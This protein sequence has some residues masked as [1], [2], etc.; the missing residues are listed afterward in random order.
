M[1]ACNGRCEGQ[2]VPP[3]GKAECEASARAQTKLDVECTPPRIVLDYALRTDTDADARSRFA[4]AM[5]NLRESL[6][7]LSAR[8]EQAKSVSA[9][10]SDLVSDARVAVK[11]GIQSA[12]KAVA[13]GDLRTIFGLACAAREVD[14]V[15]DAIKD[16]SDR[17][18]KS[19]HDCTGLKSAVGAQ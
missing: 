17:L 11:G 5:E 13:K 12:E 7:G 6:P 8:L 2:V 14:N 16:S 9:A 4:A 3:K 19:V 10:G 15:A 1:I 18:A